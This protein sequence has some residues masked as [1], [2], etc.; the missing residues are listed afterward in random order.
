MTSANDPF[1]AIGTDTI[2]GVAEPLGAGSGDT[3]GSANLEKVRDILFGNQM[4][5][6]ERRFA[7]LEERIAKDTRDLKDEIR[8]RL[9]A[10]ELYVKQEAEALAEQARNEQTERSE[11]DARLARDLADNTRAFERRAASLDELLSKHQ[12]DVRQQML[13]QHQRLTDD[14]RQKIDEVLAA[15]ARE[16]QELRDDKTD[17]RALASLL[18]EMAMRLT[19]EFRMPA[20]EDRGNG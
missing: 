17:R 14:L 8:N 16:A 10:F 19:G 20:D 18:K 12:R 3:T 4:R 15:L 2:D 1:R 9:E 6:V 7:R 5:D 13:E 11:N